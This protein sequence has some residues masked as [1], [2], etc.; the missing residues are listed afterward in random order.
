[1][2]NENQAIANINAH[3][4]E[5]PSTTN[6]I[7]RFLICKSRYELDDVRVDDRIET[8]LEVKKVLT[9]RNLVVQ[10]AKKCHTLEIAVNRFFTIIDALNKKGLP[11]LF[12]INDSLMTRE[13][14]LKKLQD[15]AKDTAKSS[16]IKGSM[17]RRE[18]YEATSNIC[19]I[20][21]EIKHIFTVKPTF[22]KYTEVDEIYHR[23]TK[24]SIPIQEWWEKLCEYQD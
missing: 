24:I 15:I 4:G 2:E 9:K 5:M 20:Q 6:N 16:N 18:F 8:I 1:M 7:I 21:N 11:S 3:M 14:Y 22:S 10:L 13:D 23:V 19:F 12:V 17:T